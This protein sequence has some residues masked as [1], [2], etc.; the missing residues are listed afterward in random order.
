VLKIR[1]DGESKKK[2][3]QNFLG[4]KPGLNARPECKCMP[5]E[6]NGRDGQPFFCLS[7]PIPLLCRRRFVLVPLFFTTVFN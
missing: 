2:V 7:L 6:T 1:C 3:L 5:D 4:I